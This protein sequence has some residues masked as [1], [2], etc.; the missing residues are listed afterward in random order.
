VN[1][2]S[3]PTKSSLVR[4][5]AEEQLEKLLQAN[6]I[7]GC[8]LPEVEVVSDKLGASDVEGGRA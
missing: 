6:D 3:V 1:D 7:K 8:S 5:E 2:E 4:A